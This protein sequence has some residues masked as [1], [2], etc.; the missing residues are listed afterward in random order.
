MAQKPLAELST[1]RGATQSQSATASLPLAELGNQ[2]TGPVAACDRSRHSGAHQQAIGK[3]VA[4]PLDALLTGPPGGAA[5]ELLR[6]V[7]RETARAE[8]DAAIEAGKEAGKSNREIARQ[9]G[10]DRRT[11]DRAGGGAKEH[12]ADLPHP[13]P[14][15]TW[16][17]ENSSKLAGRLIP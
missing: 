4:H 14:D 10:V 7:E 1:N 15:N 5:A 17:I 12:S 3:H 13:T 2:H 9:V 16:T 8:R 11:V 6:P